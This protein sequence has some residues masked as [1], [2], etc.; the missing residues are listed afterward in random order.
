M[1][2]RKTNTPKAIPPRT[3]LLTALEKQELSTAAVKT[4]SDEMAQDAR[5]KFFEDEIARLRREQ[6]PDDKLV[7]CMIDAAPFVPYIMIDGTQ[8][9]H[10]YTYEVPNGLR[11]V[12]LEQMQRSWLHQDEID[13]RSRFNAYRRPSNLT[14][15]PQDAGRP[16]VGVN[17]PIQAPA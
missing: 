12:L 13:G 15:G 11:M 17:G 7:Y 8:Y 5:D 14:I 3:D 6:I 10:G 2:A 4:V 16:T 1:A 9:F